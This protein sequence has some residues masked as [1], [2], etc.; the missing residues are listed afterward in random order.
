MYAEI[1]LPE[2]LM[3]EIITRKV[4]ECTEF[5]NSIK[6]M[7]ILHQRMLDDTWELIFKELPEL[8]NEDFSVFF[9]IKKRK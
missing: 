4:N 6:D 3:N 5:R 2:G 1:K 8:K 7:M 9:E